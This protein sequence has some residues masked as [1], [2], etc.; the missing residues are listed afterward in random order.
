[1]IDRGEDVDVQVRCDYGFHYLKINDLTES[2]N[3]PFT[4]A[5]GSFCICNGEIYNH[6][7]LR[8][9]FL[10]DY[11]FKS[12]S[13]CEVLLPLFKKL[14]KDF[15]HQLDGEFSIVLYSATDRSFFIARDPVGVRPLYIADAE[16]CLEVSSEL[17]SVHL[18]TVRHFP[19]GTYL[20]ISEIQSKLNFATYFKLQPQTRH[21]I[22]FEQAAKD[23]RHKLE[24]AVQKRLASKVQIGALLSG[25]IDSSGVAAL[26]AMHSKERLQT[27]TIMIEELPNEDAKYGRLVAEYIGSIHHEVKVSLKE[28]FE[29]IDP[30]IYII[31]TYNLEVIPNH[32]LVYLIGKYVRENTNVKVL[33]DGTGPDEELGGYWFFREAVSDIDFENETIKQL[34]DIHKTELLAERGLAYFGLEA[35]YPYLDRELVRYLLD[36]PIDYKL[37]SS[38]HTN[39][40][41]IEKF[42]LRQA[43]KDLLPTDVQFRKKLGMTHGAGKNFEYLFDQEIKRRLGVSDDKKDVMSHARIIGLETYY[44]TVFFD[45]YPF[46]LNF[47]CSVVPSAW[48]QND[49]LAM[50]R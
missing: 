37:L 16:G 41:Q 2:G 28:I 50:W 23:L 3:Q 10:T 33:L 14:G 48:R 40:E 46:A 24:R 42:I 43:L 29:E 38:E 5:D 11:V 7:E 1:M 15:I 21:S 12:N 39:G 45:R 49:A 35:R 22:S 19:P 17:K 44:K 47:D 26:A 18:A 9:Q 31:E 32:I 34:N 27:F 30:L 4:D 36:L 13:D 8:Q 6:M 20:T 25:G